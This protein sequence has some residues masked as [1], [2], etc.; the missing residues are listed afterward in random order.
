[1]DPG[2]GP[3]LTT[4]HAIFQNLPLE[5]HVIRCVIVIQTWI[6]LSQAS[7]TVGPTGNYQGVWR[8]VIG[9]EVT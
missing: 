7:N 9:I 1:M 5:T 2:S 8:A 4:L 3:V 6:K